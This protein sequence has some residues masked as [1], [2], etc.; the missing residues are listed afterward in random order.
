MKYARLAYVAVLLF[1]LYAGIRHGFADIWWMVL[2][3]VALAAAAE[4]FTY[5]STRNK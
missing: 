3:F 4:Y 1:C 2:V 5:R